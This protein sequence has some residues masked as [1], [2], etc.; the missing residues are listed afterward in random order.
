M[1]GWRGSLH[2]IQSET[3]MDGQV[4]MDTW[5]STPT[6]AMRVRVMG[7]LVSSGSQDPEPL[8]PQTLVSIIS[9]GVPTCRVS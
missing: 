9:A 7:F 4:V 8:I 5:V 2:A 3:R 1:E 6:L